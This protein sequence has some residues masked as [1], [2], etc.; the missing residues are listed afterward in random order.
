MTTDERRTRPVNVEL[1]IAAVNALPY[2]LKDIEKLRTALRTTVEALEAVDRE[3][4]G[5]MVVG[6]SIAVGRKA[7]EETGKP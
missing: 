5:G 6:I 1:S 3:D 2:L 7:L 4:P